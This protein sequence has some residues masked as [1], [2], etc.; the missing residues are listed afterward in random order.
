L[1][2]IDL[3]KLI[4]EAENSGSMAASS[5]GDSKENEELKKQIEE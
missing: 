1:K 2:I 5:P 4:K 3:N